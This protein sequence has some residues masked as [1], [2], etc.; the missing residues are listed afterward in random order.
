[1]H[2]GV[3]VHTYDSFTELQQFAFFRALYI[4]RPKVQG[5]DPLSLLQGLRGDLLL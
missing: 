4:Q 2:L 3:F 1:M 5:D